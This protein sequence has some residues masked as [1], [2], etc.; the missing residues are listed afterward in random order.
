V[1]PLTKP[2]LKMV[3]PAFEGKT[4]AF[5]PFALERFDT[6][7]MHYIRLLRPPAVA[8]SRSQTILK[9]VFTITTDLGESFLALDRPLR[10]TVALEVTA[11]GGLQR[12]D[13]TECEG[14]VDRVPQPSSPNDASAALEPGMT[15]GST[16]ANTPTVRVIELRP[17]DERAPLLLWKNGM[18][19]L[20]PELL[21]PHEFSSW[22]GSPGQSIE[23][24]ISTTNPALAVTTADDITVDNKGLIMPVW[25]AFPLHRQSL[26]HVSLRKLELRF[27][28]ESS[29]LVEVEEE[30][31]ETIARHVWD[32]GVVAVAILADVCA[33]GSKTSHMPKTRNVLRCR[34]SL[35]VLELGT[36]VG[37]FGLGIAA[38]IGSQSRA[39]VLST[40]ILLTDL[41]EAEQRA[42]ANIVRLQKSILNRNGA[43]G[44]SVEYENLDW[45]EGRH[46]HFSTKIQSTPWDLIILSDC[47]YNVDIMP[48]LVET[49]SA[50]HTISRAKPLALLA[51]KPRHPSERAL[52]KIM[53]AYDW[54][55]VEKACRSLPV[56]GAEPAQV[57]IYLFGRG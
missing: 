54:V 48:P 45:E 57:E 24:K 18:R 39:Q 42:A 47:I 5:T 32:A 10:L 34:D 25:A 52:F 38:I 30:I 17:V 51:T 11:H 26:E 50:L 13:A 55:I 53:A 33:A 20:K 7:L 14:L 31:R 21:L 44:I 41:P 37:I 28:A 9:L 43:A 36:G 27:D 22:E 35:R 3:Y 6:A 29:L 8:Y 2:V 56:L 1:I 15:N 12:D 23:V 46:G 4:Q 16:E 19:V 40:S 49:L